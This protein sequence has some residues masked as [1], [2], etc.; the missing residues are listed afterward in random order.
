MTLRSWNWACLLAAFVGIGAARA[1]TYALCSVIGSELAVVHYRGST[2]THM[3]R[4]GRQAFQ[5][6][7]ATFDTMALDAL[8]RELRKRDPQANFARLTVSDA[9]WIA[10]VRDA[11]AEEDAALDGLSGPL[12]KA[13]ADAGARH[14]LLVLPVQADIRLALARTTMGRGRAAGLGMYVD[15]S[16]SVSRADTGETARGMLGLFANFRIEI[17]DT[18]TK[19]RV[20]PGIAAMGEGFSGARSPDA[21]LLNAL[22]AERKLATFR[23]LIASGIE[24][25][26]PAL[27]D[28]TRR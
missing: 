13:A 12:V 9:K 20:A 27:L 6:A 1:E 3:D 17:V 24:N 5:I 21:N 23:R 15:D 14:M 11:A 7:D 25:S 28:S 22:S 26:L 16:A 8:E 19:A 2:G 10:S 4:L 18:A